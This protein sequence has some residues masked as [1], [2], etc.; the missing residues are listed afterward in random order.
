MIQ[1]FVRLMPAVRI[2]GSSY[3]DAVLL[4]VDLTLLMVLVGNQLDA[5]FLL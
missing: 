2:C 5:Q 3:I 4:Y 1:V